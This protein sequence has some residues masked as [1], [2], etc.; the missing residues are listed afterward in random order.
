[1]KCCD[2]ECP[3]CMESDAY[4]EADRRESSYELRKQQDALRARAREL[5]AAAGRPV[6]AWAAVR[7]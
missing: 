3:V 2:G 1:M 4:A 6:P 7:R 5:F